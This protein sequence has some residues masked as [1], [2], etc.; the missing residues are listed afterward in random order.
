MP[1]GRLRSLL[2]AVACV[3]ACYGARPA[4]AEP[5]DDLT[6]SMLTFGPGD[7]PFYKFGHDAI[8]V[9]PREGPGLVF[10]F[11]TFGFDKPNLIPKFL[12]GRLMYWLSVSPLESTLWSYESSN[13][14]IEMQELD[15]TPVERWGLY[16][17]LLTNARPE[18][19][20]Y[21][22]DYFWDNCST[23]VRDA[24]DATIG[25]R[26]KAAAL[27]PATMSLRANALRMTADLRWEYVALS[28][29]LGS[30]TDRPMNAWQEGFLP[31]KLRDLVR[32]VR[33][34]R[35]GEWRPLVKSERTLFAA[36]RPAP[37]ARPPRWLF[38]FALPGITAGA[39]LAVL[40][41]AARRRPAARVTLGLLSSLLG[42]VLG[43]LGTIL[44]AL[45]LFT[46][47][48][49]AHANANILLCAPWAV[50][51]LPL[52][53]GV[54]LGWSGARRKAAWVASSAAVLALVA[55]AAR[56]LPGTTQDNTGFL[57]LLV[58]SWLGLAFGLR[59]VVSS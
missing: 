12:R 7:H 32:T 37:L 53:I 24:I 48:K 14:T 9:Q 23:R 20:E 16:Q 45:W 42:L 2:L 33:V 56:L 5:G 3:L 57:L 47:H 19:R 41:L 46:N 43:L 40:G 17:R 54:A 8:L 35:D 51:L 18:N 58:P 55:I 26:L 27:A 31:E 49:A 30:L 29:A 11:G 6:V 52:G 50:A 36:Q 22:Y 38:W 13:R 25:G 59:Q 44:L 28:F 4:R 39:L 21:L 15:L 1:V 10:N 34:E